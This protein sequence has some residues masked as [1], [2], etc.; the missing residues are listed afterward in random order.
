[1][2]V[3]KET[4]RLILVLRELNPEWETFGNGLG[5]GYIVSWKPGAQSGAGSHSDEECPF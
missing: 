2:D 3:E 4:G 1:M 5:D